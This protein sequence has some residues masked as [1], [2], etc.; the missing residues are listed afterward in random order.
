MIYDALE[1]SLIFALGMITS[2]ILFNSK[3]EPD[4]IPPRS[5]ASYSCQYLIENPKL[6]RVVR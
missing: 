3:P 1:R 4:P 6:Q 5:L 2:L